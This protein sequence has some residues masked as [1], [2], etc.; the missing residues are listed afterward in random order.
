VL[1]FFLHAVAIVVGAGLV[2]ALIGVERE[3]G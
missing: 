1:G 2:G 3:D